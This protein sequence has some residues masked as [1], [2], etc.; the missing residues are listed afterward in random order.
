M[1]EVSAIKFAMTHKLV[2]RYLAYKN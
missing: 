1:E 2:F